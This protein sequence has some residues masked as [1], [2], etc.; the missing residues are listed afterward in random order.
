MTELITQCFVLRLSSQIFTHAAI[1]AVWIVFFHIKKGK[2]LKHIPFHSMAYF[3]DLCIF[4]VRPR[5][6]ILKSEFEKHQIVSKRGVVCQYSSH[7]QSE[8]VPT[9][10]IDKNPKIGILPYFWSVVSGFSLC[11]YKACLAAW[12]LTTCG[13]H[14]TAPRENPVC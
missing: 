6:K 7:H 9:S 2:N 3:I 10:R 14:T 1:S 4:N 5:G 8:L 12:G 13:Y 11:V